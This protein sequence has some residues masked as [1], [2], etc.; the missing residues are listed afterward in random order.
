MSPLDLECDPSGFG[1]YFR[2]AETEDFC[3][4][5]YRLTVFVIE[6]NRQKIEHMTEFVQQSKGL[7]GNAVPSVRP[8]VHQPRAADFGQS[9]VLGAQQRRRLGLKKRA[10]SI[11]RDGGVGSGVLSDSGHIRISEN[12]L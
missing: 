4:I 5:L 3:R 1:F 12:V 8:N 2:L 9:P 6:V 10:A 11:Y 7:T